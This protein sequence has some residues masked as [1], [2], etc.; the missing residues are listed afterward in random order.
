MANFTKD[1][2]EYKAALRSVQNAEHVSKQVASANKKAASEGLTPDLITAKGELSGLKS[3]TKASE[4]VL[5]QFSKA[6]IQSPGQYAA[7]E[8]S[9][10]EFEEAMKAYG[11]LQQQLE[12]AKLAESR[13]PS[14]F[15]VVDEPYPNPKP[16]GPRR[17]LITAVAFVLAGL[18]QL[19][20]MS[21][22]DE[23][24]DYDPTHYNGQ[25]RREIPSDEAVANL[26]VPRK[27][28]EKV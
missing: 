19:A 3:A 6:I 1:S 11:L 4:K 12:M 23:N 24:E 16:V 8:R 10:A 13:D 15:A 27:T 18:I 14:R 9:K 21:L 28:V 5:Q 22:R 7:V 25:R 2:P 17:G 26:E 20:I